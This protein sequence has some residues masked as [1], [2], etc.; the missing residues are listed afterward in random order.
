MT[1]GGGEVRQRPSS[2]LSRVAETA[3]VEIQPNGFYVPPNDPGALRRAIEYLLD[4]PAERERLGAAGRSS[5]E[6][7]AGLEH[8]VERLRALVDAAIPESGRHAPVA[9]AGSVPAT[10]VG[11]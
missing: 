2:L 10:P 11:I 3:G 4:R 6:R 9:T 1:R 5:V 8:Y 7:L